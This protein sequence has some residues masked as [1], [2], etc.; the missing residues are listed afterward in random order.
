M[1]GTVL[2]DRPLGDFPSTRMGRC[3]LHTQPNMW[4]HMMADHAVVFS[5][6]PISPTTTRVRTTWLVHAD[7]VEGVDYNVDKLTHVWRETNDQD[8]VFTARAQV[9]VSSPAYEAGPY[10]PSESQVDAYVGWY[11]ARLAQEIA[12]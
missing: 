5:A 8:S 6:L 9:G 7:A 12:S 10:M 4:G 3:T 1:D 2:C 11:I